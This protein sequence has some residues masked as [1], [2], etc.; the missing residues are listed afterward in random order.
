[1]N[2]NTVTVFKN[3]FQIFF[4]IVYNSLIIVAILKLS[5]HENQG[6]VDKVSCDLKI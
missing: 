6:V 5:G 4:D 3:K 1:M 2:K